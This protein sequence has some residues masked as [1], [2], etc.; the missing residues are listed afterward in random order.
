MAYGINTVKDGLRKAGTAINDFDKAY[1]KK[2]A[3][4]VH[5]SMEDKP[6]MMGTMEGFRG[7]TSGVS[8]EDVLKAEVPQG[9]WQTQAMG[10]GMKA[11]V[12]MG[13]VASRYALPAGGVTLAGA[14]LYDLTNQ[15]GGQ[16][17]QPEPGQ[18]GMG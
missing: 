7:M 16:A 17:D 2:I 11:G 9:D 4:G 6:G 3:D 12:L 10:H 8:I 5:K 18:L 1:A 13:N 14:A 15:F